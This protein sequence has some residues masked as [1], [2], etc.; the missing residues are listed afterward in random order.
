MNNALFKAEDLPKNKVLTI[1]ISS[2]KVRMPDGEYAILD[3]VD[4]GGFIRDVDLGRVLEPMF[5]TKKSRG[6]GLGLAVCSKI[7]WEVGG[8]IQ[9]ENIYDREGVRARGYIPLRTPMA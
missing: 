6:T 5:S 2:D 4:D 9:I 3:V 8:K 1:E 7:L